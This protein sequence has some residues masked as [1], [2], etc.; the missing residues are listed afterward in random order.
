MDVTQTGSV[1]M[2]SSGVRR[3]TRIISVLALVVGP[4]LFLLP[5]RTDSLFAW[6]INPPVTAAFLGGAYMTALTIELLAARERIWARARVVY[7]GMI[8]FTTV[9]L[10]A[11]LLHLDKFHFAAPGLFAKFTAWAWLIIYALA[12]PV[13]LALLVYQLRAPGGDPAHRAPL[14]SWFRGVLVAQAVIMMGLGIALFLAPP[15]FAGLWPW[16]LTP[17]T[18]RAVGAW[19]IG[20]GFAVAHAAWENDWELI[21]IAMIGDIVAGGLQLLVLARFAGTL[22]WAAPNVWVYLVFLLAMVGIGAYGV[23]A[24]RRFAVRAP[25]APQAAGA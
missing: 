3:L 18:A 24:T 19:L 22:Q 20:L 7:P 16:A 23:Y 8:L 21:G 6:T 5:D 1:R 10:I 2:V 13:M 17:L 11:T 9:T 4:L 15:T 12:P 25:Q 14:P